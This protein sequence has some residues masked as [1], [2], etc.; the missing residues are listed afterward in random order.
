M[1]KY[2]KKSIIDRLY[3][4]DNGKRLKVHFEDNNQIYLPMFIETKINS[5]QQRFIDIHDSIKGMNKEQMII[6]L[7]KYWMRKSDI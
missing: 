5:N 7:K 3:K 2:K 4:S 6:Y 1:N